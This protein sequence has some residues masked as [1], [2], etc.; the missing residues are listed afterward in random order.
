MAASYIGWVRRRG[1]PSWR[2][3]CQAD[4]EA[5]CWQQLLARRYQEH[6]DKLVLPAGEHPDRPRRG[7]GTYRTRR[8][9]PGDPAQPSRASRTRQR[10][11]NAFPRVSAEPTPLPRSFAMKDRPNIAPDPG[12]DLRSQGV[13]SERMAELNPGL[14]Q[15]M[16]R[17][18]EQQRREEA[19]RVAR[20]ARERQ[21]LARLRRR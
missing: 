4:T 13:I 12:D 3:A 15:Q 10:G 18:D 14:L 19:E 16:A 9:V 1:G 2:Q 5:A 11:R 20:L 6:A 17:L 8:M 21:D 7:K